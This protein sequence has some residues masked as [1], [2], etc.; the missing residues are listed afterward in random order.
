MRIGSI[1]A[2]AAIAAVLVLAIPA[3]AQA[4]SGVRQLLGRASDSALTRLEQPGAFYADKAIRIALPGPAKGMSGIMKFADKAGLTKDLS[5]T[6]NDAAGIAAGAAK[7]VFRTAIDRMTLTDGVGIVTSGGTGG[8]D[9]LKR[10]S[11]SVLQAQLRP[12]VE[13]ALRKTG[14]FG[15][16]EKLSRSPT[17]TAAGITPAK[18]TDSVTEQTANGIFRYMGSEEKRLRRDPLGALLG[19]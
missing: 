8:T 13:S 17:F 4:P 14:A 3:P 18:F 19:K 12:L 11:G 5:R 6:M 1:R 7:P 16:F 15:Q 10:S 2:G 9:Y